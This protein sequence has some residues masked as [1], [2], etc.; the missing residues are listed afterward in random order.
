MITSLELSKVYNREHKNMLAFINCYLKLN[1]NLFHLLEVT[2]Y[3]TN[4]GKFYKLYE[5]SGELKDNI[6]RKLDG[7]LRVPYGIREESALQAIEQVL[8]INLERQFQVGDYRIDGYCKETKTAYEID[9]P[10]HKTPKNKTA[11]KEREDFIISKL[12]CTFK[13]ITL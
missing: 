12:G 9:E 6:V 13:R 7:H 5:L 10:Q 2:T 4:R 11:D 8:N 1:Q 3:K